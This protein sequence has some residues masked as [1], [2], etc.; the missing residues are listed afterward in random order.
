L[1]GRAVE[2]GYGAVKIAIVTIG[3]T[4]IVVGGGPIAHTFLIVTF[5]NLGA[6]AHLAVKIGVLIAVAVP[7]RPGSRQ[8]H[9]DR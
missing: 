5:N 9:C 8:G 3:E 2:V 1:W 4:P 7:I 6:A